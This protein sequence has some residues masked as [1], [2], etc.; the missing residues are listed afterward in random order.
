MWWVDFFVL[1]NW[2]FPFCREIYITGVEVK[3]THMQGESASCTLQHLNYNNRAK[4]VH[5]VYGAECPHF[6]FPPDF[7]IIPYIL[8]CLRMYAELKYNWLAGWGDGKE[9]L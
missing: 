6:A 5:G 2:D 8:P 3:F 1:L 4:R 9:G 7:M